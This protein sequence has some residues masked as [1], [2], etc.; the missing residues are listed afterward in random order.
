MS[1]T[2]PGGVGKTRLALH[3]LPALAKRFAD[4]VHLV[5]LAGVR[6]A[7]LVPLALV[8]ALNIR[9]VSG[10]SPVEVLVEQLGERDLLLVLDNCE[11]LTEAC[12]EFVGTLLARTAGAGAGDQQASAG[13]GRAAC[14]G[15]AAVAHARAGPAPAQ[16]S[17]TASRSKLPANTEAY[18]HTACS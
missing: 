6:D 7:S 16:T 2:G 10:R 12:A 15:G 1:L 5:Q 14:A 9:D 13:A 17:S 18:A 3:V 4:G 8:E 11:H